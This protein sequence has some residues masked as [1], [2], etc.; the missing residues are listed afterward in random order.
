[1]TAATSAD[2]PKPVHDNFIVQL[3]ALDG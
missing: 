2:G 3:R 1:M